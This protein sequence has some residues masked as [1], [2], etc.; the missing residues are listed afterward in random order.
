MPAPVARDAHPVLLHDGT[1]VLCDGSVR[2]VLVVDRARRFRFAA[3]ESRAA[4][5]LLHAAAAGPVIAP[6][7]VVLLARGRVWRRS[8][9]VVQVLFALGG[10]WVL[11]GALLWL[12][13]K[14]VRDACYDLV[15][16]NRTR[17]F[18]RLTTCRVPSAGERERFLDADE[19]A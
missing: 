8:S 16:A 14:P 7:S 9:A 11:L 2:A 10:P 1:C 15:A 19:R 6:G 13:P 12:V 18:G 4:V 17:W 5:A 3:L